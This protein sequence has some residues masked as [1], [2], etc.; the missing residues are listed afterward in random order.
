MST[1]L[2]KYPTCF[3]GRTFIFWAGVLFLCPTVAIW[4][5]IGL[6]HPL[7]FELNADFEMGLASMILGLILLLLVLA[8]FFQ[9]FARQTPILK[10]YR[11]GMMIR[12]IGT[13]IPINHDNMYLQIVVHTGGILLLFPLVV[14]WQCITLQAFRIRTV[15][16]RWENV[17]V[18]WETGILH[19][20]G[21]IDK[22]MND[23][24]D[25][26]AA[27]ESDYA[28]SYYTASFGTPIA[29]VNESVQFFLHNPDARESLPSWQDEETLFGN[30]TFDF[31]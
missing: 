7:G 30:D 5:I 13:P 3:Y 12:I 26:K 6:A 18:A 4:F 11:E 9:V 23:V 2:Q 20:K 8:S 17:E 1:N 16:L 19:V 15:H 24:F 10:I 29:A 14:L 27:S 22:N 28:V 31:R 25:Q 21:L